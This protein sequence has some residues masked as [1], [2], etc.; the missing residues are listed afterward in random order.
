MESF[1]EWLQEELKK[2]KWRQAD[3]A[4]AAH[5]DTAVI[6]N[7]VNN[8]RGPGEETCKAIAHA[9]VLPPEN[10]FRAAGL[11]PLLPSIEDARKEIM[12]YKFD[13]LTPEQQDDVIFYI[14][15]LQAKRPPPKPAEKP[16]SQKTKRQGSNP[17]E[18]VK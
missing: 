12:N 5:L 2:R 14:E 11:L 9:F 18:V 4:R 7:L 8:K 13:E 10:V 1:G 17:G 3:L 15:Y 6:S 16:K